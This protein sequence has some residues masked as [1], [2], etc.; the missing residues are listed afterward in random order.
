MP[1]LNTVGTSVYSATN[2]H[3]PSLKSGFRNIHG[4]QASGK[5]FENLF[6]RKCKNVF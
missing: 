4:K 2:S 1:K 6:S 5:K 3:E